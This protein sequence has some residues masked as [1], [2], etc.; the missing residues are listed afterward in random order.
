MT[1]LKVALPELFVEP[2]SNDN[3]R[4]VSQAGLFTLTPSGTE[5]FESYIINALQEN[6]AIDFDGF[7]D[8]PTPE[9]GFEFPANDIARKLAPY[10]C[11]IHI[12]NERR[13]ECLAMLRKMNIH[14]GSLFPDP[15][16]AA[17][18]CNDWLLRKI[19]EDDDDR[20]TAEGARI[21]AE[22]EAKV[23][24]SAERTEAASKEAEL[25]SR[26]TAGTSLEDRVKQMIAQHA[27]SVSQEVDT[28]SWAKSIIQNYSNLESVDWVR[29]ETTRA[30]VKRGLARQLALLGAGSLSNNLADQLVDV[31][32]DEYSRTNNLDFERKKKLSLGYDFFATARSNMDHE[33]NKEGREEA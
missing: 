31:F 14:H 21:A 24:R 7:E 28:S 30:S 13:L 16:G 11:K 9:N 25:K 19:K 6:S 27:A 29:R 15:F 18:Y 10:I 22:A 26:S 20:K 3:A 1:R 33:A 5:N 23:I 12:P 8:L 4:L 32:A 2:R 17:Q